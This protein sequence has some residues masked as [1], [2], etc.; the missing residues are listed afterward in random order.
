MSLQCLLIFAL[1][2]VILSAF[3]DYTP[4]T[5]P[6]S[7]TQ[8]ELCGQ[9]KPS[10][11]CDPNNIVNRKQTNSNDS[12]VDEENSFEKELLY[13]RGETNCSCIHKSFCAPSPRGYTISIA[14]VEKMRLDSNETS[15]E[16]I[17]EAAKV[18]AD[19]IRDRQSR[20][21]C[22]DD[23]VILLSARDQVV[24]TSVG[25]M[26]KVDELV[27]RQISEQGE[28]FFRKMQYR[29]GLEWMIKQYKHVLK[30]ERIEHLWNWPLPEWVLLVLAALVLLV[31]G[32]LICAITYMCIRFCRR[33]RR[34]E[35]SMVEH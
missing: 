16:S 15:R 23:L 3:P 32:T 34:D 19:V 30:Q 5:Y 9:T 11:F 8:S 22:D 26:I 35:Y 6:D 7:M 20:G 10:F 4:Y 28:V 31:L 18:F 14:V 29:E 17:L 12:V 1:P 25:E 13:V 21:Q 27:I 33:D 2:T 24:Y